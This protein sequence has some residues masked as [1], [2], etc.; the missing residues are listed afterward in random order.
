M[1]L[2]NEVVRLGKIIKNYLMS[3]IESEILKECGEGLS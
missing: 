1:I 2:K 3:V